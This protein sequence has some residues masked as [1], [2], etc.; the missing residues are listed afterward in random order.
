MEVWK[1][2]GGT[3]LRQKKEKVVLFLILAVTLT[4]TISTCIH[5]QAVDPRC[6][7]CPHPEAYSQG[8]LKLTLEVMST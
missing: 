1:E 4:L 8:L 6:A 7:V 3:Q 2:K 5:S